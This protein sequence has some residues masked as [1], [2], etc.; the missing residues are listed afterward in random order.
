MRIG[1]Y[2]GSF[3]PPH[4]G[5]HKV[6]K[7]VLERNFVDKVLLLPTL[8]YWDKNHLVDIDERV[9]MLKFYEDENIM[10]DEVHNRYVYIYEVLRS[11]RKDY[12]NDEFYL[13]MGSDNLEKLH[14][15]K[16]IE[17]ILQNKIIVLKRGNIVKNLFLGAFESQFIYCDD[18]D[19]IHTSS[20]EIRNGNTH[21]L[22]P[23]VKKY[24]EE[25][26]LYENI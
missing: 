3:N 16:N 18:F 22:N 23:N 4:E 15:W 7:T 1:V 11:L 26:H 19:F 13:I 21:Y 9:K 25:H 17:E 14:E 12:P 10:V 5:H 2:V 24:I 20:T 8:D 6:M